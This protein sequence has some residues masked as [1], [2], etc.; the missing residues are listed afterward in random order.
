MAKKNTM[1]TFKTWNGGKI[2]IM[3]KKLRK[4]Q[5][6]PVG[7]IK[8]IKTKK[9][10]TFAFIVKRTRGSRSRMPKGKIHF[11]GT[12]PAV[13]TKSG[14]LKGQT[15]YVAGKVDG[16][17]RSSIKRAVLARGGNWGLGKNTT[18]LITGKRP[19]MMKRAV[20]ATIVDFD[21]FL[22]KYLAA[23]PVEKM[24]QAVRNIG[25]PIFKNWAEQWKA[26]NENIR[27]IFGEGSMKVHEIPKMNWE[28]G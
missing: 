11:L 24:E 7:T 23:T 21:N 9:G 27:R 12:K 17:S 25:D 4:N 5:K 15:F 20:G 16:F 18:I 22:R 14:I 8:T 10:D 2:R 19:G 3:F 26:T 28:W 6:K 1:R 13:S